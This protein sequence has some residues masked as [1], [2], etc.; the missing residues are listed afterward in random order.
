MPLFFLLPTKFTRER[1]EREKQQT[2]YRQCTCQ[3]GNR[4]ERVTREKRSERERERVTRQREAQANERSN[5][6]R[7]KG[8]TE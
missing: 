1:L 7:T 8:E 6:S 2:M 5:G 4:K 3:A